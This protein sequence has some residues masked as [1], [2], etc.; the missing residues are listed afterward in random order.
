M[1]AIRSC[2][3]A[4]TSNVPKS[5]LKL[6]NQDLDPSTGD[7]KFSTSKPFPIAPV[8][9]LNIFLGAVAT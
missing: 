6:S 1:F 4:E 2:P 5:S 3:S 9:E 8:I 7:F